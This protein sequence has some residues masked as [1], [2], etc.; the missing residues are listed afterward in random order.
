MGSPEINQPEPTFE[1]IE[2]AVHANV[3]QLFEQYELAEV[4]EPLNWML[5]KQDG[6]PEN[7]LTTISLVTEQV[8]KKIA[9]V[10]IDIHNK[11]DRGVDVIGMVP[12]LPVRTAIG[13]MADA[14]HHDAVLPPIDFTLADGRQ[15]IAGVK[16]QKEVV[17]K[18]RELPDDWDRTDHESKDY[19]ERA[20]LAVVIKAYFFTGGREKLEVSEVLYQLTNQLKVFDEYVQELT[21]C[22]RLAEVSEANFDRFVDREAA[23]MAALHL[24]GQDYED[25]M[26]YLDWD[27]DL[28]EMLTTIE[29]D[30]QANQKAQ[31]FKDAIPFYCGEDIEETHATNPN[32]SIVESLT[33]VLPEKV[34]NYLDLLEETISSWKYFGPAKFTTWKYWMSYNIEHLAETRELTIPIID[35]LAVRVFA[36]LDGD[37]G[38]VLRYANIDNSEDPGKKSFGYI[39]GR[40]V[41]RRKLI[42]KNLDNSIAD[43]PKLTAS[44]IA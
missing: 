27:G 33:R 26:A 30:P 44:D 39:V 14:K 17:F 25:A 11:R 23:L 37:A 28:D 38:L 40:H 8:P 13:E 9:S 29:T 12:A 20:Q 5:L 16:P 19:F 22:G 24:D 42:E 4:M 7:A 15:V 35:A 41:N 10:L 34:E 2:A 31:E 18:R 3:M 1:V 32:R 43:E 6:T 21:I 36:E